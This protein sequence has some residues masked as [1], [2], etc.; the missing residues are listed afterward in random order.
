MK[1]LGYIMLITILGMA[2]HVLAKVVEYYAIPQYYC[3]FVYGVI[4]SIFGMEN[5]TLLMDLNHCNQYLQEKESHLN[6]I[7]N[8]TETNLLLVKRNMHLKDEIMRL[9]AEDRERG[10]E[11]IKCIIHWRCR[12]D[13]KSLSPGMTF[14]G[15]RKPSFHLPKEI[16]DS[17]S[18][19]LSSTE[20]INIS[21]NIEQ[22]SPKTIQIQRRVPPLGQEENMD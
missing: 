9:N 5:W 8:L 17:E 7:K 2:G 11:A 19:G 6:I 13:S 12:W 1:I 21:K 16:W 10:D 22:K 15:D 3:N 14:I 20:S 4:I 18:P